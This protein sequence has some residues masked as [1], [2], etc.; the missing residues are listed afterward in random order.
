[1]YIYM[2]GHNFKS[3]QTYLPQYL[4]HLIPRNY[5]L[6]PQVIR[7]LLPLLLC[8]PPT[9]GLQSSR[10]CFPLALSVSLFCFFISH[11]WVRWH[12]FFSSWSIYLNIILSSS[13]YFVTRGEKLSS[14]YNILLIV[15]LE[16]FVL[17]IVNSGAKYTDIHI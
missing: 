6:P 11:M 1:M 17:V 4:Y 13:I 16:L 10:L 7:P 3:L 5:F 8:L 14:I 12:W 15:S 9:S 2:C